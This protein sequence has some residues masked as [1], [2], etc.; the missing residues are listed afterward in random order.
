MILLKVYAHF[1]NLSV[2]KVTPKSLNFLDLGERGVK[3]SYI[4][5]Q[6]FVAYA[7][8]S[9]IKSCFLWTF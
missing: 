5:N 6:N 9:Q 1:N 7:A 3:K 4:C 2:S 8:F